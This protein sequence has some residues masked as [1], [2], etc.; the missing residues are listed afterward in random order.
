MKV[1]VSRKS[2]SGAY[3]TD[4]DCRYITDRHRERDRELMEAWGYQHCELCQNG[5]E[6]THAPETPVSNHEYTD[7]LDDQ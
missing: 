4:P 5:P 1:Y 3:H 2:G 6:E 7:R